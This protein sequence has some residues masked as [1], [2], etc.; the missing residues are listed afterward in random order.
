[1][2]EPADWF[3]ATVNDKYVIVGMHG[4]YSYLMSRTAGKV[5]GYSILT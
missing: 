2:A 3:V 5:L 1:M 4:I